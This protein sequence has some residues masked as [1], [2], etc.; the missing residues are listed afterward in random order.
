MAPPKDSP[1]LPHLPDWA[2]RARDRAVRR[3]ATL[4][5][6]PGESPPPAEAAALALQQVMLQSVYWLLPVVVATAYGFAAGDIAGFICLTLLGCAFAA[7]LQ[8]L[9]KGAV[10]SGYGIPSVPTPTFLGAYFL[11]GGMGATL[12]EA[13]AAMIL[14]AICVLALFVAVPRL[15]S[16]I[17]ADLTGL[18]V[19][20]I[21]IS[22]LPRAF[23]IATIDQP[24]GIP[25]GDEL[26]TF[27]VVLGVIAGAAILHWKGARLALL[28]GGL[29]GTLAVVA[30]TPVDPV[31]YVALL[32]APWL[33]LPR[34]ILPEFG[35]I[36]LALFLTFF[37]A[38]LCLVPDWLG[39]MTAWQRAS[40]SGW[41]KPDPRPLRRGVVAGLLGVIG[42][43]AIGGF[44]ATT[45]SACVGLGVASRSL[46][47]IV[48]LIGAA[49]LAAIA[50]SPKIVALFMLIPGAVAAAVLGF[51]AAFVLASG[52][53]L[54]ASR[55]LDVRRTFCVGLGLLAGIGVLI[56]P[57]L[58]GEYVP[59]A[60]VSPV[61]TAFVVAFALHLATLPTVMRRAAGGIT[62]DAGMGAAIDHFVEDA[63]G[64]LGLRRVTA[65]AIR[66]ALIETS[67]VLAGREVPTAS[68]R[69]AV[70]DDVVV[71]RIEHPG[72]PLPEPA[73]KPQAEDLDAAVAAQEAFAMWLASRDAVSCAIRAH[74]ETAT[75]EFEFRD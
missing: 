32:D 57:Q 17:P 10:G 55:V 69:V 18:V 58:A 39:D 48:A 9:P 14:A 42:Q 73:M 45:S 3:P 47:R 65:D 41:T 34:P 7:L 70:V 63:S 25:P 74:G 31:A 37:V 51:V 46:S 44:G 27:L 12:G 68:V 33:A 8:A 4:L 67:E 28:I 71:L 11:A 13:G 64:A 15:L 20:M 50:F 66:H 16:L 49:M 5:H 56:K 6:A 22:M 26:A 2:D 24:R 62:L 36:S 43:G 38:V 40:D 54:I 59:L 61:T 1:N 23:D 30:L 60:L 75:V 21:G 53:S 29:G 52:A 72:A 19:L 35:G